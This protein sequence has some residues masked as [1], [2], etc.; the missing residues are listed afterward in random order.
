MESNTLRKSCFF[1]FSG[2]ILVVLVVALQYVIESK[3]KENQRHQLSDIANLYIT[4]FNQIYVEELEPAYH[5]TQ[6]VFYQGRQDDLIATIMDENGNVIVHSSLH[7]SEISKLPNQRQ[8]KEV[9]SL[10]TQDSSYVLRNDPQSGIKYLH[11]ATGFISP[12]NMNYIARISVPQKSFITLLN[13]FRIQIAVFIVTFIG[14]Y[15]FSHTSERKNV[16]KLASKHTSELENT[17]KQ[18]AGN[19]IEL[20]KASSCMAVANTYDEAINICQQLF[21]T[22]YPHIFAAIELLTPSEKVRLDC[23]AIRIGHTYN[24]TKEEGFCAHTL[25]A[26]QKYNCRSHV[27]F[28][29]LAEGNTF[30]VLTIMCTSENK[31]TTI[32]KSN[33]TQFE[34]IAQSLAL[35]LARI[36][37]KDKLN[38]KAN[39]DSM[40]HLW[41]RRYFFGKLNKWQAKAE[42]LNLRA[43]ILMID[44]DHFKTINDTLGHEA[45]D[46][47]LRLLAKTLKAN[48]RDEN[49]IAARIGGE[50]FALFCE[51]LE[52]EQ[53]TAMFSRISNMLA[54]HP[55][56]NGKI[57]TI[58]MGV[59]FYPDISLKNDE[60]IRQAD[61]ALYL[62]KERGRNQICFS[63]SN[64]LK[65][66]PNSTTTRRS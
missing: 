14:F 26:M 29:L 32:S 56:T 60:L 47:A 36:E 11:F 50:E 48:T 24:A 34:F 39:T 42:N 20:Q 38:K 3:L 54:E 8:F 37:L 10:F 35:N 65:S 53:A 27:C 51:G 22:T 46:K 55:L 59:A 4:L 44:V 30:G 6:Q 40:T 41:N 28:P 62:A 18:T 63:S 1:W 64:P 13:N 23:W 31:E 25:T 61:K 21:T 33:E 45:G 12:D 2:L 15:W 66:V 9:S 58:S 57:I 43:A 7:W 49:D 19:Y 52:I 16:L 5:E 17:I